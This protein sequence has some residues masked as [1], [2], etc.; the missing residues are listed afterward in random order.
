M[1]ILRLP[2]GRCNCSWVDVGGL[3]KA[4]QYQQQRQKACVEELV[5]EAARQPQVL[6]ARR[7]VETSSESVC[8]GAVEMTV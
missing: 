1:H 8:R 3:D 5:A 6:V 2:V 4:R 7:A